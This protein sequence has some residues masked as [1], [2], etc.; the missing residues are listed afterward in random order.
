MISEKQATDEQIQQRIL[1]SKRLAA[2]AMEHGKT[3]MESLEAQDEMLRTVEDTLEANEYVLQK[4]VRALRG[5]TWGGYFVNKVV[6]VRNS[7]VGDPHAMP[8]NPTSDHSAKQP[9]SSSGSSSQKNLTTNKSELMDFGTRAVKGP[10]DEHLEELSSAVEVLHKMGLTLGEQLEQ[11]NTTLERIEN[12]TCAVTEQTLAVTLRASQLLRKN[13]STLPSF[14]GTYQFIDAEHD[15]YLVV[16]E[17]DGVTLALSETPDLSS[18]FH[19][20][21]K[22]ENLFGLLNE[23]TQKYVGCTVWGS[24]AVSGNYFGT[25]EE[26]YLDFNGVFPAK[27][28]T[29]LLVIY[30]NWGAGGWLKLSSGVDT[31][32]RGSEWLITETTNSILEKSGA[33]LFKCIKTKVKPENNSNEN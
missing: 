3:T 33:L 8:L 9:S 12:K 27:E 26:C 28:G 7:V 24:V 16:S 20:F 11:Q 22:E 15:R 5:M 2:S 4:S 13:N 32:N 18:Y 1:E 23:K 25:H 29:G 30:R 17:S 21:V 6:D 14:I 19:C 31:K 10:E